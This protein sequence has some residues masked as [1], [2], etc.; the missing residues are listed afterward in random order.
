MWR[1]GVE[2]GGAKVILLVGS[3]GAAEPQ[4][5]VGCWIEIRVLREGSVLQCAVLC[6]V[7]WV[8]ALLEMEV[9]RG[10]E[11]G[12]VPLALALNGCG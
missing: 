11:G 8:G 1:R 3:S 2:G 5:D 9:E 10:E 4:R 12:S 7:G 6:C